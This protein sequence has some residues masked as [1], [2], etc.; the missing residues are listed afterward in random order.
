VGQWRVWEARFR[1]LL[2]HHTAGE[3]NAGTCARR[4]EREGESLWVFRDVPGVDATNKVAERAQRFGM[5]WCKRRQGT[6]SDK[7]NR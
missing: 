5:L 1:S 4:L 2:N 7:G 3:D 6:G